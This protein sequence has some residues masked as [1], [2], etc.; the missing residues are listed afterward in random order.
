LDENDDAYLK[1]LEYKTQG[2]ISNAMLLEALQRRPWSVDGV[3]RS[4]FV[5]GYECFVCEQV[6]FVLCR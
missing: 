3:N 2:A 6:V 4:N 1:Y 5:E